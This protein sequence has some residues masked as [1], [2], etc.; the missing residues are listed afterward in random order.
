MPDT[1][2]QTASRPFVTGSGAYTLTDV[3]TFPDKPPEAVFRLDD[4][5]EMLDGVLPREIT[6]RGRWVEEIYKA[7]NPDFSA[8][9]PGEPLKAKQFKITLAIGDC[10]PD[11]AINMEAER[12]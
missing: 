2:N 4:R 10:A 12:G 11:D 9:A 8:L 6:I 7:W 5:R 3:T 1:V